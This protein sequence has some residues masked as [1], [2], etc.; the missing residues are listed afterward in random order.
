M[1]RLVWEAEAEGRARTD[2]AKVGN[3]KGFVDLKIN[4]G[5]QININSMVYIYIYTVYIYTLHV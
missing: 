2:E 4:P 3:E 5:G 1:K